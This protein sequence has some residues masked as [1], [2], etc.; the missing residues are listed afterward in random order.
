MWRLSIAAAL[1]L[2]VLLLGAPASAAHQHTVVGPKPQLRKP[3]RAGRIRWVLPVA[4]LLA[5]LFSAVPA[6]AAQLTVNAGQLAVFTYPVDLGPLPATVDI[7]PDTLN[8][9][10]QGN[11]VMAYIELPAGF[12][13]ADIDVDTVALRVAAVVGPDCSDPSG[14]SVSAELTPTEVGDHDDDS[15]A[16]LMVKFDRPAVL[17][18]IDGK[19]VDGLV[20]LVV[21]GQ[22][23]SGGTTFEGCDTIDPP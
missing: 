15:I 6:S 17:A 4:V 13:V 16:D 14:D 2:V 5:V 1:T 3:K 10:S 8:P 7:D 12:N 21:S 20:T 22:L 23:L 9:D 19:S 11:H 18:L